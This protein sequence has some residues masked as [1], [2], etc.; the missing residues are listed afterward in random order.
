MWYLIIS[1]PDLCTLTY[2]NKDMD[3]LSQECIP[4]KI[5]RGKS[6]LPWITQEIKWLIRKCDSLYTQFINL[7]T[8][9]LRPNFR[10]Y[11]SKLRRKFKSHTRAISKIYCASKALTTL[12]TAKTFLL[13]KQTHVVIS[14]A[15]HL[16]NITTYSTLI[17]RQKPTSL[18]NSLTPFLRLR[19][20]YHYLPLPTC[21]C[22]T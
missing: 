16:S 3:K 14:T 1:I 4:S 9:T 12:V 8:K 19:N 6:S 15:P 20:P 13:S 2:F 11:A 18:I 10:T 7:A 22:R 5:N 21:G 17:P